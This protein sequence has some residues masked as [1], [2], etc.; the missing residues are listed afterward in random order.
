MIYTHLQ[1]VLGGTSPPCPPRPQH[2]ATTSAA[3]KETEC[4]FGVPTVSYL[5]HVV[6]TTG[7]AMDS[8]KVQAV[9]DWARPRTVRALRGFLALAGYYRRFIQGYGAIAAPPHT[10]ADQGWFHMG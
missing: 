8:Q 9:A 7:V 4:A 5:G 1:L 6:S 3:P 2:A 10:P